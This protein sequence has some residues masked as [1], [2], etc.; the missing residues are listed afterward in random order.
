MSTQLTLA[1][2][3]VPPLPVVAAHDV[4]L[5]TSTVPFWPEAM[6]NDALRHVTLLSMFVVPLAT[7]VQVVRLVVVT[8]VPPRPTAV[9]VCVPGRHEIE[10]R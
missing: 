1:S 2:I 5:K 3:P 10:C 8:I 4:P 7:F 9:Q 6:Q